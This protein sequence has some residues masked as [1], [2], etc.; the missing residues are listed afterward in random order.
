MWLYLKSAKHDSSLQNFIYTEKKDFF[1][2]S[3]HQEDFICHPEYD[4]KMPKNPNFST[5]YSDSV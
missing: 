3:I 2:K 5:I 4:Q 1:G